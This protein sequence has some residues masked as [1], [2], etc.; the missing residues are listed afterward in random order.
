MLRTACVVARQE[1]SACR[2]RRADGSV[3]GVMSDP[4]T[5]SFA[6]NED[7]EPHILK[8]FCLYGLK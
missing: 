7:D 6:Q 5:V 2:S 1:R 8:V 4:G 3:G